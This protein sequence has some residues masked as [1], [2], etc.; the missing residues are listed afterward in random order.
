MNDCLRGAPAAAARGTGHLDFAVVRL[1]ATRT[2]V[3]L[4]ALEKEISR[5]VV[6]AFGQTMCGFDILRSNGQQRGPSHVLHPL[7]TPPLCRVAIMG[8]HRLRMHWFMVL[9]LPS[10]PPGSRSWRHIAAHTPRRSRAHPLRVHPCVRLP[11]HGLAIASAGVSYICDVNGWASV[12]DSHKFWDDAANLLRQYCL[13][14]V[15]P[16]HY[17]TCLAR[18]LSP[19]AASARALRASRDVL[20]VLGRRQGIGNEE[21]ALAEMLEESRAE[22]EGTERKREVRDEKAGDLLCVVAFI[23]HGDR[24]PKQ[25]LKFSTNEPLLLEMIT[26]DNASPFEERKIKTTA[27]M[28]RLL[29]RIEQIVTRLQVRRAAA[30]AIGAIRA[31]RH[32]LLRAGRCFWLHA[33]VV[34]SA[35]RPLATTGA[36]APPFWSR[37]CGWQAQVAEESNGDEETATRSL[38][39][40]FLAVRQVLTAHP[41]HGINRKVQIKPTAWTSP[42]DPP[43]SKAGGGP[44]QNADEQKPSTSAA[45]P[46]ED[47]RVVA[48][49][50]SLQVASLTDTD[51]QS[52]GRSSTAPASGEGSSL[53]AADRGRGRS[54][55]R[56]SPRRAQE[57]GNSPE[58]SPE[59]DAQSLQAPATA[60]GRAKASGALPTECQFIMKCAPGDVPPPS[61]LRSHE[62]RCL[63]SLTQHRQSAPATNARAREVW[64]ALT[65]VALG[66]RHR[67]GGELTPLGAMQA[68]TLGAKARYALYPAEEDGVLR[69]HASYRHDLKI[70]SSDEGRVQMTAAAFAKGFLALEGELTPI[71]A[72][73]VS[74]HKSITK[75]LDETPEEGRAQMND[76]KEMIKKVPPAHWPHA[77]R[78]LLALPRPPRPSVW[79][80]CAAAAECDTRVVTTRGHAIYLPS[81]LP[82]RHRHLPPIALACTPSPSTSHRACLHAIAICLPS[83]LPARHHHLPPIALACTPSPSTSHRACLHV[84]RCSAPSSHSQRMRTSPITRAATPA[85]RTSSGAPRCSWPEMW[86]R[87]RKR[88]S[89]RKRRPSTMPPPP[90]RRQPPTVWSKPPVFSDAPPRRPSCTSPMRCRVR[91]SIRS[92]RRSTEPPTPR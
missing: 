40:K 66:P 39:T 6:R 79:L 64:N 33:R 34:T 46:E 37:W 17:S 15:A 41:F 73:L 13:Q 43:S 21:E 22:M 7:T 9:A 78:R 19:S 45:G 57:I 3:I 42:S 67:W 23:R 63:S 85:R 69:L 8:A 76:A 44:G 48:A 51:G 52:S 47:D 80:R 31:C 91:P 35:P 25:K 87:Q 55:E 70:Y 38:L 68:T 77:M 86:R 75:M 18:S 28:E 32:G 26:E 20:D 29:Q 30:H 92:S 84:R 27:Q 59:R 71:L 4:T 10:A 14:A 62:P 54:A 72:S 88:R 11:P 89:D 58:G 81:R 16:V 2:K 82:A 50:A 65:R 12:K 53:D 60:S 5:K 56:T 90:R 83:R 1:A 24:T 74:K 36:L 49:A 61:L